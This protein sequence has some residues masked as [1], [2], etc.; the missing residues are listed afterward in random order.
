MRLPRYGLLIFKL[1]GLIVIFVLVN[2]VVYIDL[3]PKFFNNR[4]T[5]YPFIFAS[6]SAV[7]LSGLLVWRDAEVT[8]ATLTRGFLCLSSGLGVGAMVVLLSLLVILNTLG[9]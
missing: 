7:V 2:S 4:P 5:Y 9:S 6:L 8:R 3:I 1:T